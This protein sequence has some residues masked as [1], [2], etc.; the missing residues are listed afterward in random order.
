M[1]VWKYG[2]IEGDINVRLYKHYICMEVWK[3][4]SME[5]L[6]VTSMWGCINI[7]YVWKYGSMEGDSNVMLTL[8]FIQMCIQ[9]DINVKHK[10]EDHTL[11]KMTF[12]TLSWNIPLNTFLS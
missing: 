11:Y 4:G 9:Y 6:K 1:E 2:S 10:F 5:V 7:I 3:Y 12:V 8:Q